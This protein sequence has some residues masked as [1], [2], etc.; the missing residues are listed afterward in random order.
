MFDGT[1][2]GLFFFGCLET[3]YGFVMVRFLSITYNNYDFRL[4]GEVP[5]RRIVLEYLH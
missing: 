1:E 4:D 3:P 2:E 5:S